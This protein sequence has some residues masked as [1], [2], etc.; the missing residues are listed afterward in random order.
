MLAVLPTNVDWD[1][2]IEVD[3]NVEGVQMLACTAA[4]C[5]I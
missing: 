2:I 1:S 3:D 5:E 4:G